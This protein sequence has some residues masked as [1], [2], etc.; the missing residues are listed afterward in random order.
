MRG[1][2]ASQGGISIIACR[3]TARD[4]EVSRIVPKLEG[5]VTTPRNDV[6]YI[7]TEFGYAELRGKS[8]KERAE[9]LIGL[10][11]PKFR[12]ELARSL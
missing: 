3:S 11:H 10:A 2:N 9:A 12:D 1:A 5:P 8:L 7:V 6:H 4:G